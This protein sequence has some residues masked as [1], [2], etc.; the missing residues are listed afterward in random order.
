MELLPEEQWRGPSNKLPSGAAAAGD[1]STAAEAEEVAEEAPEGAHIAQASAMV[2]ARWRPVAAACC[3]L[4]MLLLVLVLVLVLSLVLVLPSRM[5]TASCPPHQ[6]VDPGEHYGEDASAAGGG[7]T[8]RPTGAGAQP[9]L[10]LAA[11]LVNVAGGL[12]GFVFGP[13]ASCCACC[14]A[15]LGAGKVV[16]II[17]RNWRTRGY[18]GSL[19]VP[20]RCCLSAAC[21]RGVFRLPAGRPDR[22]QCN[23][24]APRAALCATSPVQP[25]KSGPSGSANHTHSLLFCPVERRFP[26]IRI[27]TRQVLL[28]SLLRPARFL[29]LKLPLF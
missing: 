29:A 1:A 23:P 3:L 13:M 10:S 6:Q 2:A 19:Q 25:P 21:H 20:Y 27:Q 28:P 18:C 14:A 26:Y 17:R 12:A 16:G 4:S 9:W 24:P 8:K 11:Q 15:C 5:P 22:P 7:S